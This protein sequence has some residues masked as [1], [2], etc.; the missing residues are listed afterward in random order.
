MKNIL[1]RIEAISK[2]EGL[3]ITAFERTIGASKGVLS[4]AINNGTDIQSKWIQTIVE[5][6]PLY[7]PRWLLTGE[8]DMISQPTKK[9]DENFSEKAK[10]SFEVGKGKPYYDVDFLGGFNEIFNSQ[11]ATPACNIIVPG[12]E[13]ATAWCNVTGQ[14]M[15]PKINHG[16][17]IALR[18][19]TIQDIQYGEIYAVVL[20]TLRTIKIIRRG[21]NSKKLLFV[22]IN[23]PSYQEQE[24]PITRII[25]VFEV[26]GSVSKFF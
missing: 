14:S 11:T 2:K 4:R 21:S 6:Y 26:I 25:K 5:N 3:T 19:C 7:S 23:Q 15:E 24:F 10:I 12:F 1:S 17:I 8:G 18:E 13:K 16:D 22:P 20:D 9:N